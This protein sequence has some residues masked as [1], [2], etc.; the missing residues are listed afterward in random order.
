MGRLRKVRI[1]V[2]G[3]SFNPIHLGHLF[4]AEE[5][6]HALS[7]EQV[8]FMTSPRPPLKEEAD[9]LDAES[10]Y[11]MAALATSSNPRFSISRMEMERPGISYTVDTMEEL[12]KGYP[13]HVGFFF[14]LGTDAAFELD[15]WKDPERL[16][17]LC[18]LAV[19]S[20]PG[21][22]REK[23]L[24]GASSR[25]RELLARREVRFVET[26]GLD[27][28]STEIRKRVRQGR[29]YRYLLPE[30]VA[31]FIENHGIYR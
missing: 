19:V 30:A 13:Q 16:L 28:S 31:S 23:A 2:L 4:A 18:G 12:K 24:A 8:I 22:D 26:E 17:E 3:G 11:L 1:G 20:R 7:L 15:S 14:I 21:F 5:V 27:I 25:V 29:P 9:L 10:R 6:M